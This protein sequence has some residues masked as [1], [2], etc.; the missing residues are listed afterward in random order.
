MPKDTW[1]CMFP[2]NGL[3]ITSIVEMDDQWLNSTNVLDIIYPLK[4]LF[5]Q[6]TLLYKLETVNKILF[7]A[8]LLEQIENEEVIHENLADEQ[9][10]VFRAKFDYVRKDR[11]ERVFI[12][13]STIA[14]I[15]S[16]KKNK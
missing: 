14:A 2:V 16:C 8:F 12:L 7:M 4:T 5:Y 3:S 11:R 1:Q 9:V 6:R 13:E 10:P 15:V